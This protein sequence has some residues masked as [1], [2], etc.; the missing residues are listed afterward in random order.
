MRRLTI[1]IIVLLLAA[2]VY[3]L[4]LAMR[5]KKSVPPIAPA[6]GLVESPAVET[7]P[8][9]PTTPTDPAIFEI[10]RGDWAMFVFEG[11]RIKVDHFGGVTDE[12]FRASLDEIRPH[13]ERLMDALE[14]SDIDMDLDRLKAEC[15]DYEGPSLDA[16]TPELGHIRGSAMALRVFAHDALEHGR[17]GEYEHAVLALAELVRE[18]AEQGDGLVGLTSAAILS[19][20]D[21][22]AASSLFPRWAEIPAPTRHRVAEALRRLPHDDPLGLGAGLIATART[23]A[24][25]LHG[26]ADMGEDGAVAIYQLQQQVLYLPAVNASPANA[27]EYGEFL[28]TLGPAPYANLYS[29]TPLQF[30]AV[31]STAEG[32]IDELERVWNSPES[33][34]RLFGLLER[35][36][37][38]PTHLQSMLLRFVADFVVIRDQTRDRIARAIVELSQD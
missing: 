1:L 12:S 13:V 2:G 25:A 16:Y 26:Y 17:I 34:S 19:H 35:A 11:G 3:A 15:L 31:I 22:A 38:D 32:A 6:P 20:F 23:Q 18:L 37:S 10:P 24:R 7:T 36:R 14:T 27:S 21:P 4:S 5:Q 28:E 9:I 29:L 8:T 30:H 33:R